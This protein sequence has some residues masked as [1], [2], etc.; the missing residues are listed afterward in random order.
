MEKLVKSSLVVTILLLSSVGLYAQKNSEAAKVLQNKEKKEQI[1]EQIL[2]DPKLK[3]EMMQRLEIYGNNKSCCA[4]M[5]DKKM[6]GGEMKGMM[7]DMSKE[8]EGMCKMC[9]MMMGD[10]KMGMMKNMKHG[11]MGMMDMEN[12]GPVDLQREPAFLVNYNDLK[13]ALVGDKPKEAKEAASQMIK[14]LQESKVAEKQRTQ[15]VLNLSGIANSEDL[16]KQRQQ[17]AQLSEELYQVVKNN[18]LTDKELYL[19]HCPMAI[20]GEGADWLSYEKQV[21]NP[22]MGQRMPGCGSVKEVVE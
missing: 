20:G 8:G 11:D 5:E 16:K 14:S 4:K 22:Y 15:L 9:K 1:F 6:N 21:R 2:K 17:F 10:G 7:M 3:S 12:S 13:N 18:D 19:Q